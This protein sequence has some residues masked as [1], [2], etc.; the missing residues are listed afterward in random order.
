MTASELKTDLLLL[1]NRSHYG[2]L[3]SG[4]PKE[5]EKII[6]YS[7]RKQ[8][9]RGLLRRSRIFSIFLLLFAFFSLFS[10][11]SHAQG[12]FAVEDSEWEAFVFL[13]GSFPGSSEHSTPVEGLSESRLVGLEYDPGLQIG[14]GIM[15][16]RWSKVS[17]ALEYSLS[18]QSATITN[19]SDLL[20]SLTGNHSIHRISYN[21]LYFPR[22]RKVRLQPYVFGGPGLS[23]FYVRR[24]IKDAAEA[25]GLRLKDPWKLTISLGGGA[26]YFLGSRIAAFFQFGDNISGVPGYGLPISGRVIGGQYIPGFRPNG[27][28]HNWETRCGIMFQL[29]ER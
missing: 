22:G 26:R 15:N 3:P 16:N 9:S 14:G 12:F 10:Q 17:A 20:P 1:R 11:S 24:S 2:Y 5:Q 25:L 28:L 7:T 29:S 8:Q 27:F 21:I 6:I 4:L 23:L 18:A 13:G 19:L